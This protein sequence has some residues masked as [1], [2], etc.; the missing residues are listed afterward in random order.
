MYDLYNISVTPVKW[1][2]KF[3]L[4]FVKKQY[5]EDSVETAKDI[6]KTTVVV[7]KLFGKI[8]IVG[9]YSSIE[10]KDGDKNDSKRNV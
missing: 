8:Y 7:K 4:F 9:C 6:F 1:W 5:A 10:L 2:E 3:L